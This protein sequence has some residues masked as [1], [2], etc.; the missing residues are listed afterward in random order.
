MR[1]NPTAPFGVTAN[2][3]NDPEQ[4]AARKAAQAALDLKQTEFNAQGVEMNQRYESS[5]VI[6]DIRADPEKWL[7]DR[8]LYNQP[9]TRPGPRFRTRGSSDR[10][11]RACRRWT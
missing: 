3:A 1:G 8:D 2:G 7:R 6:P 10:T 4:V 9:T 11:V 5:A